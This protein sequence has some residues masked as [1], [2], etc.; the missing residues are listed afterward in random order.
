MS[1]VPFHRPAPSP[2][3]LQWVRDALRGV[4]EADDITM[5]AMSGRGVRIR[6]RFLVESR[7]AYEHL[8]P[9]FRYRGHT[10]LFRYEGDDTIIL[11][12]PGIVE[13]T[14]NNRWLPVVLAVLT[15]I[16][17][18]VTH[19]L[20]FEVPTLT[21]A[22]VIQAL[23]RAA[24]FTASL[25]AILLAHEMGHYFTA[26]HFGVAVTPPYLIPFPFSP[27]GT[28]GAVI[29]MKDIPPNR[30]S[31]LLIGA[32]G[33]LAGLVLAIPI[34][35]LGLSL[36]Q[37]APL[38]A[39]G[40]Y[41]LEGNSILYAALKYLVFGQALPAGGMDV[42]LHPIAM[43]GWA[44]LLVTSFNLIPAGQLDGGHIAHALLGRR[45]RYL[46]WAIIA[47]LAI[48][49][50]FWQGWLL[51]A[52]LIFFLARAQ[53]GPLDDISPLEAGEIAVAVVLLV[54]FVL[55]FTPFPMRFIN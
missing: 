37:L 38:P 49:G 22:N 45:A 32:A 19:M 33:P 15:V 40:G 13:P 10:V 51:W 6:G 35:L 23:P 8:A 1:E 26:R 29:R 27:F 4:F 52:V 46:T 9:L 3:H 47:L 53:M 12:M 50:V 30:K 16:S 28:M 11:A 42:M 5:G 54:L 34:L 48:L 21:R 20:L 31:M 24:Q 41:V 25:V 43:A 18:L 14:P 17:M 44:G 36:S 2:D 7:Q 39:E 55:T